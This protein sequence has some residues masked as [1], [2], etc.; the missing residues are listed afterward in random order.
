MIKIQM[1]Q[2][3]VIKSPLTGKT[4]YDQNVADYRD[5]LITWGCQPKKEG[6]LITIELINGVSL[7]VNDFL[8]IINKVK[9]TVPV[10]IVCNT[11]PRVIQK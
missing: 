4:D 8:F 1:N 7:D 3:Y 5:N 6:D 10:K 2:K 9:P 11:P